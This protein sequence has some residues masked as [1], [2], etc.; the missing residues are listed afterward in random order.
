[1][2]TQRGETALMYAAAHGHLDVVKLLLTREQ[3]MQDVTGRTALCYAIA[4]D[5]LKCAQCL[6]GEADIRDTQGYGPFDICASEHIVLVKTLL[7]DLDKRP[8]VEVALDH[9]YNMCVVALVAHTFNLRVPVGCTLLMVGVLTHQMNLIEK[10]LIQKRVQD[11]RGWTACMY[12]ALVNNLE[13]LR[14]LL[15]D[16]LGLINNDGNTALLISLESHNFDC[17]YLLVDEVFAHDASGISQY[18]RIRALAQLDRYLELQNN[19]LSYLEALHCIAT[20]QLCFLTR[21]YLLTRLHALLD[22]DTDPSLNDA[23]WGTLLGEDE[24]ITILNDIMVK[25]E[26][27]ED[28]EESCVVCLSTPPEVIFLQCHHFV[29]CQ[30][31]ADQLDPWCPIC[32]AVILGALIP[33]CPSP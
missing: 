30:N 27:E 5:N 1:M 21:E 29:V 15:P 25:L 9:G 6:L 16:E 19:L 14:I 13:A 2:Q 11:S 28:H 23:I 8:A 20:T 10:N 22:T 33:I 18:D 7:Q 4:N 24:A 31:C 3:G 17:A 32:Q 26:E 12:A